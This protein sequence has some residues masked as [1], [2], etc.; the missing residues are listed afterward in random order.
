MGNRRSLR[1]TK[2]MAPQ[3]LLWPRH[4]V[5]PKSHTDSALSLY[6]PSSALPTGRLQPAAAT[7]LPKHRCVSHLLLRRKPR[8]LSQCPGGV[9]PGT[10]GLHASRALRAHRDPG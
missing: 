6:Q 4:C 8:L 2:G 1:T 9:G 10:E 5:S 7:L 3:L